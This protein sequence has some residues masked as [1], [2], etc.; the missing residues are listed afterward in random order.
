MAHRW[1]N[2]RQLSASHWASRTLVNGACVGCSV[3]CMTCAP[4]A[5]DNCLTCPPTSSETK[6]D[7]YGNPATIT[8]TAQRT[9]QSNGKYACV[10]SFE[11]QYTQINQLPPGC[12]HSTK[13]TTSAEQAWAQFTSALA[14]SC[15]AS[16][17]C[18]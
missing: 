16:Y 17:A 11:V 13:S 2:F 5:P 8:S 12:A 4:G 10:Y 14:V 9:L 6:K 3:R 1:Q 18:N 15:G 7:F